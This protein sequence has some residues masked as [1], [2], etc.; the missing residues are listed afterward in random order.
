MAIVKTGDRVEVT[1]IGTLTDGT[2]FDQSK[3]GNALAFTLGNDE[4]I[5]GFEQAVMGM[6]VGETKKVTITPD[7]AYGSYDEENIVEVTRSRFPDN[8]E[9]QIGMKLQ[10]Q[11]NQGNPLI[12]TITEIT[13]NTIILDANHELAGKDLTF[14]INLVKILD[15]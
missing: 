5:P 6:T 2:V 14:E 7:Q 13:K 4:M 3:D 11:D 9:P 12:V 1:Y 8:L 15:S 10:V